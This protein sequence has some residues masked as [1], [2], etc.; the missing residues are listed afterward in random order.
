MLSIF[1]RVFQDT[2]F[3]S[4]V[5][6]QKARAANRFSEEL[7]KIVKNIK[8]YIK[9]VKSNNGHCQDTKC[10][11][12]ALEVTQTNM[13]SQAKTAREDASHFLSVATSLTENKDELRLQKSLKIEEMAFKSLKDAFNKD[14]ANVNEAKANYFKIMM[15]NEVSEIKKYLATNE[16][17]IHQLEDREQ[18]LKE[19]V[20]KAEALYKLAVGTAN[21]NCQH[22][23]LASSSYRDVSRPVAEKRAIRITETLASSILGGPTARSYLRQIDYNRLLSSIEMTEEIVPPRFKVICECVRVCACVC[24]LTYNSP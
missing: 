24:V 19:K 9:G 20:Q 2:K 18:K 15:D 5:L 21:E 7:E 10:F 4:D 23:D 6:A 22:L 17:R 16:S 13:T 8:V 3:L 11:L 1:F 14:I 12:A